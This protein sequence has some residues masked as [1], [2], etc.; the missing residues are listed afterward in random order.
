MLK[1]TY[2]ICFAMAFLCF[3]I[4]LIQVV[5]NN[6][7]AVIKDLRIQSKSQTNRVNFQKVGSAA[8]YYSNTKKSRDKKAV[9]KEVDN[10]DNNYSDNLS[11]SDSLEDK[12]IVGEAGEKRG[13]APL[14]REVLRESE[15][16]LPAISCGQN[17]GTAPLI[18]NREDFSPQKKGT[19]PLAANGGT[20]PLTVQGTDIL[21][22]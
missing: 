21:K 13:T 7:L 9:W 14:E 15:D 17:Y 6:G 18:N 10:S 12:E 16:P 19:R 5:K 22:E 2:M 20:K 8:S 1:I 3:V 4:T 11:L